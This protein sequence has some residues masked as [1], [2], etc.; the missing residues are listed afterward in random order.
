MDLNFTA[1]TSQ[2]SKCET[3]IEVEPGLHAFNT[4]GAQ[5]DGAML[6]DQSSTSNKAAW[7]S[8]TPTEQGI[9]RATTCPDDGGDSQ[10]ETLV[11]MYLETCIDSVAKACNNIPCDG[12]HG[13]AE[14][15]VGAGETVLIRVAPL[16]SNLGDGYVAGELLID[17]I[18][19]CL[20]DLNGDANVDIADILALISAWGDCEGCAADLDGDGTVGVADML[21]V[22]GAWG[23]CS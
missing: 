3:A 11:T 13:G 10:T 23:P 14:L 21:I 19:G 12:V 6:C 8:I 5:G 22:I 16:P 1:E 2:N 9:V 7:F 17:I 20:G 15:Q 4:M 18:S